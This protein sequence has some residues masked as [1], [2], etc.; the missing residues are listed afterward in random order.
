MI[1]FTD[2]DLSPSPTFSFSFDFNYPRYAV[3]IESNRIDCISN[4]ATTGI[5]QNQFIRE[6][7]VVAFDNN[8]SITL[9]GSSTV[10][11]AETTLEIVYTLG[12]ILSADGYLIIEC[13]K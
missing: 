8:D 9:T 10:N 3:T 12:T 6:F 7:E 11:G 13:P 4:Y 1:T 2:F 5:V